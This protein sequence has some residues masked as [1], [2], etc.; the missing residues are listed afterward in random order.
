MSTRR[1][2]IRNCVLA[3]AAVA[4]NETVTGCRFSAPPERSGPPNIVF[5]FSDD[6]TTQAIGAYGSRINRTP[7]ID[8]LAREGMIFRNCFV[9]NS[10]CAP[11]RAVVLTGKHSHLN[12]Q[13]TNAETFDGSQQ[14]FPKLLRQAGYQTAM[15]GKW[16]LRSDPT[17]FDFWK[18]LIGQGPYYN[19]EF[20]TP[21]GREQ[22]TGYTTEIIADLSLDWLE[23]GRDKS[24]PFLLM[25][26]HK[27]PHREWEPGPEYLNRYDDTVIP[28]PPT[29]FDDYRGRSSAARSQEMTI[30]GH[31]NERD[32]KFVPP[33]RLNEEQL[34]VWK[35]AYGPKNEEFSRAGLEGDDLT[36]WKYQ[37]YLKDY[38][39][40]IDAVDDNVGRVLDYLDN[41]GLAGNTLVIYSSDQGFYLGEHGWYDKRWMYE[42]S[43]RMPLLMRWPGVTVAGSECAELVQNLDF[44]PTFIE[45]AGASVPVDM[46]GASLR[47]LLAGA[48]PSDWRKSV[49]YH[50]YEY[51]AVHM[52]NRH[53]GVRTD[54]YK[55]I[56][57]YQ[58]DEWEL[59]DLR[60]DPHELRSLYGNPD[61]REVEATLK[62]ELK[63]LRELYAV[64]EQDPALPMDG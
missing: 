62:T 61:Y 4:V 35:R 64:P 59:F 33:P 18:V 44:A 25:C 31:M 11:S 52:V 43:L 26:Q 57:F 38:L 7:N 46:Q 32:L 24:K 16:H 58:L 60:R 13:F 21:R 63:R 3:S 37:R 42:E 51:P 9:T 41:N 54:R 56:H 50:Y 48:A 28:E 5:I 40:C 55:L 22:H 53:Y 49:Y 23:N 30:A 12:G 45:A 20:L 34:A 47:P 6:H 27:A 17:G 36:R 15:I 1:D 8:R 2:F 10:I 29:M 19:P 39:R 14:T